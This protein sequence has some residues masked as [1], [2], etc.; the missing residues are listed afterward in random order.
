MSTPPADPA[1]PGYAPA[2]L[3]C[4]NCGRPLEVGVAFCANCGTRVAI[5]VYEPPKSIEPTVTL[6]G[7][8]YELAPFWPRVGAFLIDGAVQQL[9]LQPL[10][11][12][13]NQPAF[14]SPFMPQAPSGPAVW[15][16]IASAADSF[17]LYYAASIA[18]ATVMTTVFEAYGWSPGKGALGFRVVRADGYRPGWVHGLARNFW[19]AVG[20]IPF[21]LGYLWAAWDPHRQGWHDKLAQTYV[22]RWPAKYNAS[23]TEGLPP[24]APNLSMGMRAWIGASLEV[25]CF[26]GLTA[27]LLALAA[28]L[29]DDGPGL[30]RFFEERFSTT[31]TPRAR[32]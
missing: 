3:F 4:S 22:V 23:T 13:F 25:L 17:L 27:G 11:L 21:L 2:A 8:T 12:L 1:P 5:R 10:S 30:Q 6:G 31:P 26:G 28:W 20:L 16:D 18:V 9:A 19:K 29:P 24:V 32:P 7:A 15:E 14:G